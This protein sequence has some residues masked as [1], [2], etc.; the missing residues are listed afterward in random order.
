M[1]YPYYAIETNE[2]KKICASWDECQKF[3]NRSPRGARYQGF[4]RYDEAVEWL[5]VDEKPIVVTSPKEPKPMHGEAIA[6]VDG[7]FNPAN[8][9]YGYGVIFFD[10]RGRENL[11]GCDDMFVESRNIGGEVEGAIAAIEHAVEKGYSKIILYYDYEGIEAWA[12][13]RWQAKTP[14]ACWYKQ[15][16]V[17][18]KSNIQVEFVKVAGHTGVRY[19]EEVDALAKEAVGL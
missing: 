18:F 11:S 13:G 3:R 9:L 5:G 6:Y 12:T 4:N 15:M 19:N 17:I 14:V 8:G 7:S 1:A 10:E 16:F 2:G